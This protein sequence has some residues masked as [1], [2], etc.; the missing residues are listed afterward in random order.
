[1]RN[2]DL[3]VIHCAD[4]PPTMDVGVEEIRRWHTD[5]PPKGNGWADIGYHWV[6]RRNGVIEFGRPAEKIGAHVAGHNAT[7]IGVCMVGG[8]GKDGKPENNYTAEQWDSLEAIVNFLR[9]AYPRARVCGHRDLDHGKACPCF[10][11]A[12]WLMIN[13]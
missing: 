6:I 4:T 11:V 8:K 9:A 1:M 7:S 12:K 2:I 10:D 3:I 13:T 5:P